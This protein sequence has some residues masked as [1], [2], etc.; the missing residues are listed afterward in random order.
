MEY[1]ALPR[2]MK[3]VQVVKERSTSSHSHGN[4]FCWRPATH[5]QYTLKYEVREVP[6]PCVGD[7]EILIKINPNLSR[8]NGFTDFET[9]DVGSSLHRIMP[10]RE[11]VGVIVA[12]GSRAERTWKVGQR[13]GVILAQHQCVSCLPYEA[14]MDVLFC[15]GVGAMNGEH[16]GG[17]AEYMA[18]DA[19]QAVRFPESLSMEQA[20]RV[21]RLGVSI[22]IGRTTSARL[23]LNT[24]IGAGL[25]SDPI[26]RTQ[27]LGSC[28]DH[29]N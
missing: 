4:Y 12:V 25:D 10:S 26:R 2:T 28:G 5:Q 29:W 13:S 1:T 11:R 15:G 7:N 3:T 19:E 6:V 27:T 21:L 8:S 23:R 20:S 22:A 24:A 16:D 9:L 18:I 17:I 14:G